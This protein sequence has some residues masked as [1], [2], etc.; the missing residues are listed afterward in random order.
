MSNIRFCC[1][2]AVAVFMVFSCSSAP[3]RETRQ[4][5]G[6]VHPEYISDDD[7]WATLEELRQFIEQLNATI[8]RRD[9]NTW[10]SFLS[11]DYFQRISSEEFLQEMSE[12]PL[13]RSRNIVL[14]NAHDYFIH[15]VV[16]SRAN[17]RLD[18]IDFVTRNRVRA[19]TVT[20]NRAGEEQRL[21]LYHLER[22]GDLWRIISGN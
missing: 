8:R 1:V 9:F 20:T 19:F 21:L 17:A 16:P 2:A 18:D 22:Y 11:D 12:R 10:Q 14:R 13:M 4:T 15:V 5:N 7:Y 3:Q 6:V